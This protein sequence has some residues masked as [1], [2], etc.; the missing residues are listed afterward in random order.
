LLGDPHVV[1]ISSVRAC[2]DGL[3]TGS[4]QGAVDDPKNAASPAHSRGQTSR[5]AP[6]TSTSTEAVIDDQ[7]AASP[8][9]GA[10]MSRH[11]AASASASASGC[12]AP[13]QGSGDASGAGALKHGPGS[14]SASASELASK[15]GSRHGLG[16]VVLSPPPQ[17]RDAGHCRR[18]ETRAPR[19]DQAFGIVVHGS[20]VPLLQLSVGGHRKPQA[21]QLPSSWSRSRHPSAQQVSPQLQLSPPLHAQ[22]ALEP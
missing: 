8:A 13:R 14:A 9:S 20:Q 10:G 4:A 16:S 22:T 12:R 11:G 7:S 2:A 6:T 19:Q 21:P 17:T 1:E 5:S 15:A 3:E 18:Q